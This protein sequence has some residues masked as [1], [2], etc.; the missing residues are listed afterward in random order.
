MLSLY[1]WLVYSLLTLIHSVRSLFTG[2][3]IADKKLIK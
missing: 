3:S 2:Q 1:V